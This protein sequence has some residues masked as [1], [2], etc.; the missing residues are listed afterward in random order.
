MKPSAGPDSYGENLPLM[1]S[2]GLDEEKE[3]RGGG[4]NSVRLEETTA[5]CQMFFINKY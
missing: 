1:V 4:H 5:T 2:Q 3:E